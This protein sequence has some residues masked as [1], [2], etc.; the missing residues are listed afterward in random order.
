V[1]ALI[2]HRYIL[3]L[4]KKLSHVLLYRSTPL[5][6]ILTRTNYICTLIKSVLFIHSFRIFC[7]VPLQV[8]WGASDYSIDNVSELTRRS[9]TDNCD[10][11][12]VPMW[13]LEWNS[14]LRP[15][16]RKAPNLRLRHHASQKIKLWKNVGFL[17]WISGWL[18]FLDW[19]EVWGGHC[20]QPR[21]DH[22]QKSPGRTLCPDCDGI[23]RP[24]PSQAYN[25]WQ[26]QSIR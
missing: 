18:W 15:S 14:N 13:R 9:A 23:S 1:T 25:P 16:V 8:L 24:W 26:C 4:W 20:N 6:S 3:I 17:S 19:W 12:K 7:I 5:E 22:L 10:L 2:K 11:P 21:R